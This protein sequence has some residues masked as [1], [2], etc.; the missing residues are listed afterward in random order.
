[1]GMKLFSI[2]GL[3][4]AAL[5]VAV[6]GMANAATFRVTTATPVTFLGVTWGALDMTFEQ[7]PNGNLRRII[8]DQNITVN[9]SEKNTARQTRIEA[10]DV[11]VFDGVMSLTQSI[12]FETL[13]RSRGLNGASGYLGRVTTLAATDFDFGYGIFA[14]DRVIGRVTS[15]VFAGELTAEIRGNASFVAAVPLPATGG[16]MIAGLM[17]LGF[18]R[19]RKTKMA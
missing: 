14:L 4:T 9:P 16:M 6:A 1:M 15:D 2:K 3:A 7:R 8:T 5:L 18:W 11:T 19:K 17:G 12:S 10:V 13:Y